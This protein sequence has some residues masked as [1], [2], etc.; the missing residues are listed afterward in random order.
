MDSR[1]EKPRV[2]LGHG[3]RNKA[4]LEIE[5]F[6]DGMGAEV[7]SYESRSRAGEHIVDVLTSMLNQ[8]NF[9]LLVHTADDEVAGGATRARENVVHETGLFQARLGFDKAIVIREE[10]TEP[11]S[12]LEGLLELRFTSGQIRDVFD[13]VAELLNRH[14]S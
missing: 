4:W 8:S 10:G 14:F 3:S 6:L 11:F 12:N 5:S 1:N 7:V 9:A 13:K 2:F